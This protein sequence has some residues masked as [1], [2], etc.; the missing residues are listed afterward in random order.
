MLLWASGSD[1]QAPPPRPAKAVYLIAF[2]GDAR[3]GDLGDLGGFATTTLRLR[4]AGI[5]SLKY[6]ESQD[7]TPCHQSSADGSRQSTPGMSGPAAA[8]PAHYLL[9]GSVDVRYE[10]G[11]APE[12]NLSYSLDEVERCQVKNLLQSR[13]PMAPAEALARFR[14]MADVIALRL[15]Q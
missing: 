13:V 4:L 12:I 1:A 6:L 15:G 5:N 10:E 14:S 9:S 7:G 11:K 8:A 3:G 2:R